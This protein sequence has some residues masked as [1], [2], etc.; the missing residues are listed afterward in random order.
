M[1]RLFIALSFIALFFVPQF[2]LADDVGQFKAE[3]EKY[4][5]AFSSMDVPT[6]AQTGYPG[7]V[8]FDTDSPF[9]TVYPDKTAFGESIKGWFSTMESLDITYVN[10]QYRVN[11]NYGVTWGYQSSIIKPKGGPQITTYYRI[12]M[13]FIKT[14]GK[15]LVSTIHMSKLPSGN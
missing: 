14:D 8:L 7:L 15:W 1:R 13:T 9:A 6:I 5:Q 2:V 12:T 3:V 10:P 4:V 11:G